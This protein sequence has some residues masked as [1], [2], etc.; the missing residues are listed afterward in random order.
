L[1]FLCCEGDEIQETV[2]KS[3]R[4]LLL[5]STLTALLIIA[6][7]SIYAWAYLFNSCK[8]DAVKEA[9]TF[10]ITQLKTYDSQYQFT[11]TVY[12]DGI[13]PPLYKLQQIFMDTQAVAVPVCMQTTKNEL[14][15]YMRTVIHAF[16]VFAAGDADTTIRD[17]V[18]QSNTHYDNFRS[19]LEAVNK[20]APFCIP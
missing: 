6:V 11:T 13:G 3:N 12:Q 5:V 14:L 20:C 19:E 10:L 16:Q 17:L 9:S 1:S 7:V 2:R 18:D 4:F 8:V 15:N